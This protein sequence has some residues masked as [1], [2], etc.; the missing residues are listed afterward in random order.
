[1]LTMDSIFKKLLNTG[2][3]A[4]SKITRFSADMINELVK[5]GKISEEEGKSILNDLEREGQMQ[6]QEIEKEFNT[7]L[8]RMIRNM[9]IPTREDFKNLEARVE[10]LERSMP[11]AIRID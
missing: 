7:Y 11:G 10:I 5:T 4:A 2:I 8:E 9:D 6:Q 1:M 3:G